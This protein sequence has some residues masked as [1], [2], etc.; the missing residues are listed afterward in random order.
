MTTALALIPARSGSQR[1]KFKNIRPLGGHPL[2]AYAI[3]TALRCGLFKRVVVT[4]DSELIADVG[5]HYGADVPFLRPREI[6][7][8]VSPNIEF[9]KHAFDN[10][11]ESYDA[12]ATLMATSPFRQVATIKRAW[13]QFTSQE[14]I[15]SIRAV[16]LCRQHPGKMWV[17]EEDIMRP[18][19]DQ[20]H[21]EVAWHARQYQDM[22]EVYVQN[23]SLEIA[24]SRVV[25]E[26]NTREGK[27]LAPFLTEGW[28]GFAIDYEDDFEQAESAVARGIAKLP[29]IEQPPYKLPADLWENT[30]DN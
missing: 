27:V 20:S 4:T 11:P 18:L 26:T 15:D 19:L 2:M 7:S 30:S 25:A 9:I 22:P 23:S 14:G 16:E 21:L 1:V 8:T 10:L 3:S 12:F 29:E 28:E 5:R 24:W 13:K 6:A 17:V